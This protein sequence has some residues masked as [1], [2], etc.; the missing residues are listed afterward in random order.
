MVKRQVSIAGLILVL[1]VVGIVV[2]VRQRPAP[3]AP[4]AV[5]YVAGQ[6]NPAFATSL[7]VAPTNSSV[8]GAWVRPSAK[9]AARNLRRTTFAGLRR[10]GASEQLVERMV[11]ADLRSLRGAAAPS[12]P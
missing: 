7:E 1:I 9:V 6:V 8:S 2:L 12:P 4:T 10:L 11:Q 5:K 3:M